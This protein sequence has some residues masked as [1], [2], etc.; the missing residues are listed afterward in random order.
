MVGARL[1]WRERVRK[2]VAGDGERGARTELG[3][4]PIQSHGGE[5][6]VLPLIHRP[7]RVRLLLVA[8]DARE[9]GVTRSK[10]KTLTKARRCRQAILS[11]WRSTVNAE[12]MTR[13]ALLLALLL[14]L[15]AATCATADD[16][17]TTPV[18]PFGPWKVL[19]VAFGASDADV[20]AAFKALA[21]IHHP[22]KG[23]DQALFVE[24]RQAF[25]ELTTRRARWERRPGAGGGSKRPWW[26]D[27]ERDWGDVMANVRLEFADGRGTLVMPL[28]H[29]M[30]VRGGS[31]GE[32]LREAFEEGSKVT[33]TAMGEDGE[34]VGSGEAT[35]RHRARGDGGPSLPGYES[36]SEPGKR[37]LLWG[38][39]EYAAGVD[40]H[41][42]LAAL[43]TATLLAATFA[44]AVVQQ[45]PL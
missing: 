25:E 31:T 42:K 27:A 8:H 43:A 21:L 13:R 20:R 12:E 30:R 35:A 28:A 3:A 40:P 16:P 45:L 5:D 41:H 24:V 32:V 29:Y 11:R 4:E 18:E 39:G 23:G 6:I 36:T 38:L 14:A 22:D 15:T 34:T 1:G 26:E 33:W 17:E 9:E 10:L 44:F 7:E 2:S 19:G 37:G